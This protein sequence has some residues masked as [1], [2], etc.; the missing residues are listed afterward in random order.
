MA[1]KTQELAREALSKLDELLGGK[2]AER[3]FQDM[4]VVTRLVVRMRDDLISRLRAGETD[5]RASLDHVNALVSITASAEMPLQ[6]IHWERIKK[7]RDLLAGM[8]GVQ[9]S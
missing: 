7:T 6:G 3:E 4:S 2:H 9:A 5:V 8:A 1:D